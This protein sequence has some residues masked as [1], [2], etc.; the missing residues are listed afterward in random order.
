MALEQFL[1]GFF[2][3]FQQKDPHNPLVDISS[4]LVVFKAIKLNLTY[5]DIVS[6]ENNNDLLNNVTGIM[7]C[8]FDRND[9]HFIAESKKTI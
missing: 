1:S 5:S 6:D 8:D 9:T 4:T 7:Y 2:E 3:T